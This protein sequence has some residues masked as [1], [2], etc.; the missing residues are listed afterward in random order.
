MPSSPPPQVRHCRHRSKNQLYRKFL[1]LAFRVNY[2]LVNASFARGETVADDGLKNY[3]QTFWSRGAGWMRE[4]EAGDWGADCRRR[5]R[6]GRGG[7]SPP[8]RR[9]PRVGFIARPETK[10]W[11]LRAYISWNLRWKFLTSTKFFSAD[12]KTSVSP[13]LSSVFARKTRREK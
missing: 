8:A 2:F 11:R 9:Y 1:F 13:F 12:P 6:V 5:V 7:C 4:F 10:Q 3:V